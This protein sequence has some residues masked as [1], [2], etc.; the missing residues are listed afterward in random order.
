MCVFIGYGVIPLYS[1]SDF[2]VDRHTLRLAKVNQGSFD[3]VIRAP[4]ALVP[5]NVR[6]LAA[7]TNGRVEQVLVKPGA[8]VK[9]GDLIAELSNPELEQ[10]YD[11]LHWDL[12][13]MQAQTSA[14]IKDMESALL[15]Q[16][17]IE[18]EAKGLFQTSELNLNAQIYLRERNQG[19]ISKIEFE[20]SQMQTA[21]RKERWQIEQ[22]RTKSME[23]N[24]VVQVIAKKARL[25]K[26]QKQIE[27]AR[28][29]VEQ[30]QV[31]ATMDSV[32]QEVAIEP[33]Q[34]LA[35]GANIAKL[36]QQDQL[37]ARMLVPEIQIQQVAL[38]QTVSI[39]TRNNRITGVVSRISPSVMNGTV[40]VDVELTEPLPTDAR[41]DLTIDG[42]IMVAAL[43]NAL[44]VER[45]AYSQNYRAMRVFKLSEDGN[46]ADKVPVEFGRGSASKIEIVS[47][48]NP[49]DQIIV[50]DQSEL[51]GYSRIY[52]A[53]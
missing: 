17:T 45:P 2:K 43:S 20:S 10:A 36:V 28:E 12:E 4:G 52:L 18:L 13:A 42:E 32:V 30:L 51:D 26:L 31:R 3:I 40:E 41:P 47:G 44:F 23:E 38:A 14:E 7:E 5:I 11:D 8:Q 37:I 48:L 9:T 50:S 16:R 39:D 53:N 1:P 15:D 19:S 49:S 6:W 34:Q 35:L 21:Q 27:R 25:K 46:F 33:G 29:Q 24:V 22:S